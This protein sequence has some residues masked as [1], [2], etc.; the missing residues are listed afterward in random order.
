[1]PRTSCPTCGT[2]VDGSGG[3][4]E[5]GRPAIG[6]P[7]RAP[8]GSAPARGVRGKARELDALVMGTVVLVLVVATVVWLV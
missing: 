1:M 7:K 6:Q 4:P 3:C 8:R 5:C 2:P